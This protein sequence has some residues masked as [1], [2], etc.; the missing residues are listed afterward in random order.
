MAISNKQSDNLTEQISKSQL[1]GTQR[2]I[3]EYWSENFD[4]TLEEFSDELDVAGPTASTAIK[5]YGWLY[6]EEH[7]KMRSWRGDAKEIKRKAVSKKSGSSFEQQDSNSED[8]KTEV[9]HESKTQSRKNNSWSVGPPV[10]EIEGIDRLIA[11]MQ[12]CTNADGWSYILGDYIKW[13]NNTKVAN[14]VGIFSICSG[15]DC[16]NRFTGHCQVDGDECYAVRDENQYDYV[17]DYVRR[18]EYLWDCL[19]A[20]T[21]ADAF[22]KLVNRRRIKTDALKFNQA[23]DFRHPGDVFKVNYIAEQLKKY[24][25]SVFTYSASNWL[26]WSVATSD[27]LTVNQSNSIE[28]FG[29]RRYHAV[30][31]KEEIPDDAVWCIYNRQT[32]E[33]VDPENKTKC[34]ECMMCIDDNAP[35]IAAV[36]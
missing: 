5:F 9:E 32:K 16:P 34:G 13:G 23:G 30:D 3:L 7:W 33:D 14:N 12:N 35:D 10:N 1:T 8:D 21:F 17:L 22:I 29:D 36:K 15:H 18:Q 24:N 27:N 11:R 28:E 19:D 6:D 25:I 4:A 31:S 26:D 2:E 20:Q